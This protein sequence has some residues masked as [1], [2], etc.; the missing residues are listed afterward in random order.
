VDHPVSLGSAG[1]EQRV[2]A[3]QPL[4]VEGDRDLPRLPLLV[5]DRPRDEH[6][7]AL[8]PQVPVQPARVVLVHD[9]APADRGA[10]LGRPLRRAARLRRRVE[11]ALAPVLGERGRQLNRSTSSRSPAACG[12]DIPAMRPALLARRVAGDERC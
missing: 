6:A 7:V 11:A 1:V 4:A 9:E 3:A 10:A 12:I 8:E 5:R 2:A